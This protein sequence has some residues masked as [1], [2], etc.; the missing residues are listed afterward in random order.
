[1][2]LKIKEITLQVLV[3]LKEIQKDGVTNKFDSLDKLT[4]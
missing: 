4:I 3:G 2:R 1:M